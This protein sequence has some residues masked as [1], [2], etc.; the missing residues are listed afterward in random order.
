MAAGDKLKELKMTVDEIDRLSKAFKDE[1]FKEMLLD[2]A[3]ELSDPE[4]K[5]RYE[6]EIKLLEQERGNT[7][8]FIHPKPSRALKTSVN[9]KQKCFINI[10]SNDKV[11]KPDH[12]WGVSEEGR[13]GQHWTLPHSLHPGREDTDPKGNKIVIFD[14]IFHPDTLHIASRDRGFTNMVDSTAIQGIQ[15]HFK[16]TLDKNNV[17]E[18]KSKYKGTM[19]PC[20][21]RKPIPGYKMSKPSEEPDPLAFPY[22]DNKR[23]FLQTKPTKSPPSK[24]IIEDTPKSIPPQKAKEPTKPN[25][26]VKYRSFTDIQDFRYSRD[27]AQSPRP[28]EIVVTINMPLLK[29]AT[30]A[31]LEV[32]E[33]RLLLLE[34]KKPSYRLELPLAYA[35]DEDKGEA[36]FN[37]QKGQLTVT[38][39]V[40]PS[41]EAFDFA[42]GHAQTSVSDDERQEKKNELEE[43]GDD[44]KCIEEDL[45]KHI[46]EETVEEERGQGQDIGKEQMNKGQ[47]SEGEKETWRKQKRGGENTKE[48]ISVEE[49]K[50]KESE[51]KGQKGVAEEKFKEQKQKSLIEVGEFNLEKKEPHGD[52]KD[53]GFTSF[54]GDSVDVS[55]EGGNA[56]PVEET[57]VASPETENHIVLIPAEHSSSIGIQGEVNPE[58]CLESPTKLKTSDINEETENKNENEHGNEVEDSSFLLQR[59]SEESQ[60]F[61]DAKAQNKIKGCNISQESSEMPAAEEANNSSRGGSDNGVSAFPEESRKSMDEDD[62]PMEQIFRTLGP[63]RKTPTAILRE[64]DEDGNE[65]V[66]SDHSTSAGF[67]FQNSLMFELD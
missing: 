55:A 5:K 34:S 63:A 23:P 8:E 50:C 41:N 29:A 9:G 6:E 13:R 51:E 53:P 58:S 27:S 61:L 3:H 30:E 48:E 10:C 62:L 64:I 66:I 24:N 46:R 42:L 7:I 11:G 4:N 15:D 22:P 20:V 14:V 43:E 47:E 44:Q 17:R 16:V 37:K 59:S 25:Y 19:Q 1:K 18:I 12:K 52:K 35:V 38:L 40:L 33:C 28:K 57:L 60:I 45:R 26:T 31:S 67:I 36:K 65:K 54:Q 21:I 49:A 2:Y 32:K 56:L 39:P